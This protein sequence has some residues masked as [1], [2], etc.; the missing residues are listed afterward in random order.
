MFVGNRV[1]FI[2]RGCHIFPLVKTL[3]GPAGI[4]LTMVIELEKGI[5]ICRNH[6]AASVREWK[7]MFG[8]V[9]RVDE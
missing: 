9:N 2:F 5:S 7:Q 1:K 4:I 3:Q 6:S 8:F